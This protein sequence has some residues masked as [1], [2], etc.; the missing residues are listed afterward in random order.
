LNFGVVARQG[1][2]YRQ[3][4]VAGIV[5][6]EAACLDF[7]RQ[8]GIVAHFQRLEIA[9]ADAQCLLGIRQRDLT[10]FTGAA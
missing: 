5:A 8:C 6:Q 10:C 7:A 3:I 1:F 9:A 4:E 2:F